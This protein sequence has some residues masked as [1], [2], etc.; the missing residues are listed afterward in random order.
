MEY[1]LKI[2]VDKKGKALINHLKSLD[3]VALNENENEIDPVEFRKMIQR[4]ERSKPKPMTL[5]E[6]KARIA[7]WAKK[8]SS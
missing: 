2:K 7:V 8:R 4:A 1:L 3:F 6:V 5:D